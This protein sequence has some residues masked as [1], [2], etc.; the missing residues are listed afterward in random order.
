MENAQ[1]AI[2]IPAVKETT[3]RISKVSILPYALEIE[4]ESGKIVKELPITNQGKPFVM[5]EKDFEEFNSFIEKM[6]EEAI[7]HLKEK[8]SKEEK[9][10][11]K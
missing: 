9:S 11:T 7:K 10:E 4:K 2:K 6:K 8:P 5:M 1:L 3:V